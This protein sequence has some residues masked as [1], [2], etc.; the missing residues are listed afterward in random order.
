[1]T[2]GG[3][4]EEQVRLHTQ[5]VEGAVLSNYCVFVEMSAGL[6]FPTAGQLLVGVAKH[7]EKDLLICCGRLSSRLSVCC[8]LRFVFRS[9]GSAG[10]R[11]TH[12]SL[13]KCARL[14]VGGGT[15]CSFF[16]SLLIAF[17]VHSRMWRSLYSSKLLQVCSYLVLRDGQ[18][19]RQT[20]RRTLY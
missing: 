6:G 19:D 5:N 18:I 1:M 17:G 10:G 4:D 16:I 12:E 9:S 13:M 15:P 7:G 20:D 11:Y 2:V 3:I 8:G 14:G